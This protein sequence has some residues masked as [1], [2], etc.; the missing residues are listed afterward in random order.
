MENLLGTY[1]R[2]CDERDTRGLGDLLGDA[3]LRFGTAAPVTGRRAITQLYDSAFAPGRQTRHLV[4]NVIVTRAAAVD[5]TVSR[6]SDRGSEAVESSAYY[7]RWVLNPAPH[8]VGIGQYVSTFVR[9]DGSWRFATHTV[10]R[11]WLEET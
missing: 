11:D 2:L 10:H 4:S 5:E 1:A 3:E 8:L 9:D 6:L 7:T